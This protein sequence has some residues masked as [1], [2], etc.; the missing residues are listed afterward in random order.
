MRMLNL[1]RVDRFDAVPEKYD[2]DLKRC[3]KTYPAPIDK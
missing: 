3:L 2:E 1:I